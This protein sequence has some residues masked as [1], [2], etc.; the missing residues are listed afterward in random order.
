M[1]PRSVAIVGASAEPDSIGGAV[2]ANLDR[3]GY[4]GEI[5][6][7]SRRASEINNRRC[8]STID[9]LPEH[10]DAAVLV[11]PQ[12]AV[13]EAVAA[14]GRRRIGSAVVFASG[15]AEVD[16]AGRAEQE[17]LVQTARAAG[18][19]LLGPNCIGFTNFADGVALTFEAIAPEPIAGRPA[20][21][22]VAQSGALAGC[23][24][25]ALMSK[26]LGVSHAVSTGNEADLATEDFLAFL[27]DDAQTRAI[28][29][30]VEQI[31]RP[32]LFL[33]LAERAK[34]LAK[35]IL[36]LH[37]GKSM[38]ARASANSH[39]GALAGDHAVMSTLLRHQ[40]V[41][42]VDTLE[43]LIDAADLLARGRPPAGGAGIVTSSGAIKGLAF[44]FAET[45]GLDLPALAP[46]TLAALKATLPPFAPLDNP[47]DVTAQVLKDPTIW[48]HA[49]RALLADSAI[50]SLAMVWPPGS[51]T[52]AMGKANAVLPAI[53]ESGKLAVV[54]ALGDES[55]LPAEFF[56]LLRA[57]GVPLFRSPER[58]LRA[59]ALATAYGRALQVPRDA[60]PI[61][62]QAM[63]PLPR[64]GVLPEYI[65]KTCL[66]ALGI[67]V[68]AGRLATDL[69]A[70]KAI[71][72]AIDYPVVLKAQASALT[73]KSDAGGVVLGIEGES[74]L[75]RAWE[76][77]SD[78]MM[79]A[80]IATEGMLVETMAPPGL[81]MIVG[82]RRDP[83]WGPVL[84]VGH[85]G[86]WVEALRD[87]RL[88]PADLPQAR[89]L[90]EIGRL[91]G[92][93]LLRG[94]RGHPPADMEALAETVARVGALI[95]A[96][97]EVME[98]EINPL[99][100]L[101]AGAGVIALDALIVAKS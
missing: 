70:A 2:L 36:L 101:A 33:S 59:L 85:G 14:C 21:G 17:R 82:A 35:P 73:H 78:N 50:G 49:A 42:L 15:F 18:V 79:R 40:A 51:P 20:V 48:T 1:R 8:V 9:E 39:T 23:L 95:R 7:V 77:I 66:A 100:V 93:G 57:H 56:T 63:Q 67:R 54:V 61:M 45:I 76:R 72:S 75:A 46:P 52:Q 55:P 24:R 69:A 3:C 26:G 34:S 25:L 86:I 38:R 68:P 28:A 29:L 37:P 81:E 97:P 13:V 32:Q 83:D 58:A 53:A 47:V 31:R 43:E 5:H 88:L 44:D 84:M 19:R 65:G 91:K 10:I 94:A 16:E 64:S 22:A 99:V 41:L 96:R 12:P 11:V 92:A 89:V 71:A 87:V 60:A 74:A 4:R 27:L 80:G 30:F 6:L 62:A 98:I 90:E